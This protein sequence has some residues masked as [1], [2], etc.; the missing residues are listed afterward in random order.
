MLLLEVVCAPLLVFLAFGEQ[1]S[2]YVIA[3]GALLIATLAMHELA[4]VPTPAP[5]PA[6]QVPGEETTLLSGESEGIF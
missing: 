5:R 2:V 1:P 6:P 4:A 3:G